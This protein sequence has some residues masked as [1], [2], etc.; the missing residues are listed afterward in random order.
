MSRPCSA[1][2]N[3]LACFYLTR[4]WSACV[5]V[6]P[7]CKWELWARGV[8]CQPTL[9]ASVAHPPPGGTVKWGFR[10]TPQGPWLPK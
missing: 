5:C 1:A 2:K 10:G 4:C 9:L 8:G 3:S 7:A 6:S